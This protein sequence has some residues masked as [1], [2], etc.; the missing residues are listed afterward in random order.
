[1]SDTSRREFLYLLTGVL[2]V[3]AGGGIGC[4][5]FRGA[6]GTAA[7][8][9]EFVQLREAWSTIGRSYLE[10]YPSENSVDT[11]IDSLMADLGWIQVPGNEEKLEARLVERIQR[12]FEDVPL[13]RVEGWLLA[14][15]EARLCAVVALLE[16]A[17]AA[18]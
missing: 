8:L 13:V 16:P 18:G 7:R 3:S 5:L 1:M 15:T 17:T 11:L 2:G 14:P 10:A 12:E 9:T 6:E 4:G